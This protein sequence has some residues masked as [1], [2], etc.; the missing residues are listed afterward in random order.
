MKTFEV[1]GFSL[2]WSTNDALMLMDL[3]CFFLLAC[4]WHEGLICY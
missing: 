4:Q 2:L 3:M 1:C